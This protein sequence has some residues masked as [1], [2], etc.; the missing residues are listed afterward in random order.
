MLLEIEKKYDKDN[1]KGVKPVIGGLTFV[2][3]TE[4]VYVPMKNGEPDIDATELVSQP[5]SDI[6]IKQLYALAA[7]P[8]YEPV[9]LEGTDI[10]VQEVQYSWPAGDKAEAGKTSP[11]GLVPEYRIISKFPQQYK[12]IRSTLDQ[13]PSESDTIAKRNYQFQKYPENMIKQ[14]LTNYAVMQSEYIDALSGTDNEEMINRIE[15][16]A[17][18]FE[19]LN[20]IGNIKNE[21]ILAKINAALE[22]QHAQSDATATVEPTTSSTETEDVPT[23]APTIADMLQQEH[24]GGEDEVA[25]IDLGE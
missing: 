1:I 4:C 19:E 5:L 25:S 22:L 10:Y 6:R 7:D 15:R 18:V 2:I 21:D 24:I 12:A 14:S 11:N 13:L 9:K 17:S 20:L 3:A 23:S 16:N 8:N